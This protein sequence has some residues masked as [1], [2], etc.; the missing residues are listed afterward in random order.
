MM[1]YARNYVK[2][3]DQFFTDLFEKWLL[4]DTV[5]NINK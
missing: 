5:Y 1:L 3:I 4:W 2:K